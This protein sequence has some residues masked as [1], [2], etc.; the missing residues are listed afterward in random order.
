M[1]LAI[2]AE[3]PQADLV[4]RVPLLVKVCSLNQIDHLV[5]QA[6]PGVP[7][8]YIA[9]PPAAI[10][11]KV[12]YHYFGLSQGGTV[13]DSILRGRNLAVYIPADLPNPQL[14]LLILLPQVSQ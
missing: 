11:V 3:V 2:N 14:E 12:D 6:L 8:T 9:S 7:L 1:Y 13:W 4:S 5:R 10:P